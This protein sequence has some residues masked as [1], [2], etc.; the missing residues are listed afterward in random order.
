MKT[1]ISYLDPPKTALIIIDMQNAFT[2][3]GKFLEVKG[4]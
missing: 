4:I 2:E 1:K 3:K